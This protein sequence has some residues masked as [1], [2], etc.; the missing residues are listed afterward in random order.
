MTSDQSILPEHSA[1]P[2][3]PTKE[4]EM[5]QEEKEAVRLAEKIFTK[6]KRARA[7]YDKDWNTYF[8][9]FRGEQWR[10]KRP[11]YRHSERLTSPRLAFEHDSDSTDPQPQVQTTPRRSKRL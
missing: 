5:S 9:Y 3:D 1:T 4:V 11:S 7:K 6:N 2:S 8:K 10:Q